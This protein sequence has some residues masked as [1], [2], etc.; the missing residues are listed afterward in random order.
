MTWTF[1]PQ[2]RVIAGVPGTATIDE[3][4]REVSVY[5]ASPEFVRRHCGPLANRI[6]DAVPAWYFETTAANGLLPNIDVRVHRLNVGEYPAVP[7][8]H[9][10]GAL[11][12]TYFSQPDLERT[13]CRDHIITTISSYVGGVSNTEFVDEPITVDLSGD[14]HK[15]FSLWRTVHR[16][17]PAAARTWEMTDGCL[18]AFDVNTLHRAQP[19]K[20]RGWRLFFRLSGWHRDYLGEGGKI[21]DQQQVYILSEECGW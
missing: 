5:A 19:A 15:E 11:R 3:L 14:P 17:V 1:R 8:W 6:L 10:D 4:S 18:T 20:M 13:P 12:E 7:G 21:A 2:R 16:Q 9:C